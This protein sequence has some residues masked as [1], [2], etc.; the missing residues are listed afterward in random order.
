M[1]P[2]WATDAP[3]DTCGAGDAYAAGVLWAYL[4][5]MGVS[6]MGRAGARVASQVSISVWGCS[7][8]SRALSCVGRLA[9]L[10]Q[11]GYAMAVAVWVAAQ[12]DAQ[13]R[14][15]HSVVGCTSCQCQYSSQHMDV[16]VPA[17]PAQVI[18]RQGATLSMQDAAKLV[19]ELPAAE[20]SPALSSLSSADMW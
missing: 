6:A 10:P 8:W 1:P 13:F 16:M 15:A 7:E 19:Q 14:P 18:S 9:R 4:R 11:Q 17:L 20:A 12:A 5:G 3:V 2:Y